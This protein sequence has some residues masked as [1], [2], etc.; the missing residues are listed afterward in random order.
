MSGLFIARRF[1]PHDDSRRAVVTGALIGRRTVLR[2]APG[3]G[4]F[5]E[6]VELAEAVL[7][8]RRER[9]EAGKAAA[10]EAAG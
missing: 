8:P 1:I 3:F 4:S 9:R 5:E 2:I 6:G 10:R 7:V